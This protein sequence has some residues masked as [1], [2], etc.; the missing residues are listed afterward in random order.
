MSNESKEL[1][2]ET[3]LLHGGQEPDPTTGSRAVPIYQTSSYVF[4][5]T[6]HAQQLFSLQQPG[7]IYT[8]IMNPTTDVFEKRIALLEGGLGALAVSSGM[9]A[10]T[11]SILNLAGAGDEIVAATNLYGGTYNLFAVTLPKYGI[12]VKFVD[13]QDPENFRTAITDKT[14]AV[15]AEIIGNP[16]L[17]VLDVEKVAA[18]AH[19][20][21][22]PLIVDN[23]FA[24]PYVC[25]PIKW[26][27]DIV[28]HSATKWIGG[29]GNSIG[30]V[31]V[32]GG[33]FDWNSSKFPGFI[34]PDPSYDGLRYAQDVGE[35]AYITKARVQLLRDFGSSLSPFNAF[36]LLQGLETLHLRIKEHNRNAQTIAEYLDGHASVEWVSHP[37]L[38]SHPSHELAQKY[39]KDGFGSI[40]VFGIKG[41]REAGR[42]FI[43]HVELWSHL[44]NVGDAKSLVIHPASTTHLQLRGEELKKTGVTEDLVRLSVG[45]ETAADLIDDLD[46]ALKKGTAAAQQKTVQEEAVRP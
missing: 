27:A 12:N 33:K 22:I 39:L 2:L 31:I 28:V 24:T 46:Q 26:G 17:N 15:F 13:A 21:G 18:V 7:N 41:G 40:V 9:A 38:E 34:E 36:L 29:H 30:G 23:T 35:A 8:R 43:D 3:L 4:E 20:N 37:S 42:T 32:D 1:G 44:A 10:I 11:L 5:D 14:K 19:D 16:S 6:H 25:Q 45:I